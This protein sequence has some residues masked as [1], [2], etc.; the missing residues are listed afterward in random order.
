M[1]RFK[2]ILLNHFNEFSLEIKSNVTSYSSI[3]V[4]YPLDLCNRDVNFSCL[5]SYFNYRKVSSGHY[6]GYK[7]DKIFIP[8]CRHTVSSIRYL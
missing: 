8:G 3:K 6:T 2:I 1:R 7:T 4:S 5:E